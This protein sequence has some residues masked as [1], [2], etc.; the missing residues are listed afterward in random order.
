MSAHLCHDFKT[1]RA[2]A[3]KQ[4]PRSYMLVP[5][6]FYLVT[7][8]GIAVSISSYLSY[9]DSLKRRDEWHQFQADQEE[10]KS[11]I[12]T[13][14]AGMKHEKVKAETLAQWVEGTRA[15]QPICVAVSRCV[16]PEITLGELTLERNAELPQQV[17]LSVHINAGTMDDVARIQTAVG[18]LSYRPYNSQQLKTGDLLDFRSMLI[19]QQL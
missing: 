16:S 7:F 1:P 19:W 17:M 13:E 14:M 11:R 12:D 10:A 15:L 5:I 9:R 2:D 6:L 4:L 8:G 3:S 18:A